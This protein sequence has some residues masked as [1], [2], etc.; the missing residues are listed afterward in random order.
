MVMFDGTLWQDDA[1]V[2]AGLRQKARKRMDHMPMSGPERSIVVFA[3][4]GV[5]QKSFAHMH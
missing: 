1:M 3:D 2:R 5:A 4:L